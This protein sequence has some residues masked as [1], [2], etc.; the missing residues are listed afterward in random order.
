[1]EDPNALRAEL[2]NALSGQLAGRLSTPLLTDPLTRQ[3]YATDAS[4][5][6]VEPLAVLIPKHL[7]DIA[8]AIEACGALDIPII[9]RGGGSGLGGQALGR[10]LVIDVSRHLDSCTIDP[11]TR[12]ARV[13]PGL[14]LDRLNRQA[15][16]HGLIFGPDPASA[17]RATM[18]GI[19][20][21]NSTG[22]HSIVHGISADHLLSAEVL[23]ADGSRAK[24]RALNAEQLQ[25]KQGLDSLEGHIYAQIH[26]LIEAARDDIESDFPS[27]WRRAGGY[28]LDRLLASYKIDPASRP[29]SRPTTRSPYNS[30]G[31]PKHSASQG[32]TPGGL[33][34][35]TL[36]AGSEGTLAIL[37]SIEVQLV[38]RPALRA[39]IILAYDEKLAPY[40]AIPH[41]LESWPSAIELVDRRML[42][43]AASAPRLRRRSRP[44]SG[45]SSSGLDRGIRS[46]K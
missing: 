45:R 2:A 5:Y 13:G 8:A 22:A 18:A 3:L 33:D 32:P 14:V 6:Q 36:L 24:I 34:L 37:S 1:M 16:E 38:K 20:A 11:E 12:S 27:Y 17:D 44:R 15:S 46:R 25:W 7:D 42:R 31:W 35:G 19:I 30:P 26:D 9:A 41:L 39:L 40:Q 43:L 4:H 10:G 28:N 23:L 29:A 21:N